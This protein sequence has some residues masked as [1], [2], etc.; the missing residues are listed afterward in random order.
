MT[1]CAASTV[2]LAPSSWAPYPCGCCVSAAR[3]SC[4]A[5]AAGACRGC[6]RPAAPM[7][8]R[9]RGPAPTTQPL[10]LPLGAVLLPAS[11]VSRRQAT[12]P[13]LPRPAMCACCCCC[14][15]ELPGDHKVAGQQT[16]PE[17]R[18]RPHNPG[19]A[20][21]RGGRRGRQH[22]V[23]G[24]GRASGR[25]HAAAHGGRD[26]PEHGGA[27]RAGS[28]GC[29]PRHQRQ[30]S[31]IAAAAAG[32]EQPCQQQRRRRGR[33]QRLQLQPRR[34]GRPQ[35]R[36]AARPFVHS[37]AS[38]Q[39]EWAADGAPNRGAGGL[40]RA[41][42]RVPALRGHVRAQQ[43]LLVGCLRLLAETHLGAAGPG[44]GRRRRR[45][46]G[47]RAHHLADGGRADR[48]RLVSWPDQLGDD[49]PTGCDQDAAAGE[50][51]GHGGMGGMRGGGCPVPL[52]AG[53]P[54]DASHSHWHWSRGSLQR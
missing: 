44:W 31:R 21:E 38:R 26:G 43:R 11:A 41:V 25:G 1:A 17:A 40:W 50:G 23:P 14:R 15:P 47:R 37:G 2:V 5:A 36:A 45:R 54:C 12:P 48:Q 13:G 34:G 46:G 33:Q 6:R 52:A 16:G 28:R 39:P 20:G 22:G 49:Q 53:R 10:L 29:G 9:A 8:S 51:G 18:P 35:P 24:G 30:R 4:R 19:H 42:P 7:T 32:A 3:R 27:G